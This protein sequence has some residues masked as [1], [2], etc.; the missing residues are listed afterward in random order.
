MPR[1]NWTREELILAINL[2]CKI[3]F[4]RIHHRNK[5]VINLAK[6]LGRSPSAVSWKLVNFA[7]LDPS[8]KKRGIKGAANVSKLD[9][10]IWN[11][12]YNNWEKLSYESE[13]LLSK[14][15][16]QKLEDISGIDTQELPKEGKVRE[17]FIKVRVNQ[18]F[19]RAAVLAAYD[20]KCA[21][22]ALP[23]SELLV[24]SHIV[25]WSKDEKNRLNPRNGICLNALHD[26]AFDKGL[27]TINKKYLILVSTKVKQLIK[28]ETIQNYFLKFDNQP[29]SLPSRFYPDQKFLEYHNDIV[30]LR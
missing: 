5:E 15:T 27:I 21:I 2:Y 7:S 9:K 28:L 12:F 17:A 3:P 19:F 22:T 23:I 29:V 14:F 30:F 16:G 24:A 4:G 10:E 6:I 20:N 26:K 25:P 1:S 18:N 11:E 13:V 8:L